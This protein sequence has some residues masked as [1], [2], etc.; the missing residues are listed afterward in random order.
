LFSLFECRSPATKVLNGDDLTDQLQAS[1]GETV[2][3]SAGIRSASFGGAVGRPIV[4]GLGG[5]RVKTT[6][7]RIDSLDVSVTSTDHA[8]TVEP[9]IANQIS[10]LKG[11]STLLYGSGAIGGVVDVETGRIPVEIP[12]KPVSG[13]V[14]LRTTDNANARVGALRLDGRLADSFA[15]HA[16]AF[17]KKAD[18]Y[19]IAGPLESSALRASEGEEGEDEEDTGV[20]EGSRFDIS[21]G[22][23][24]G[25]WIGESGFVGVSISS[26]SADYGLVGGHG[27]EEEGE[28]EGEEEEEGVGRIDLEQTRVDLEAQL[29]NPL[30]GLEKLNFRFGVNDYQHDEI[31]GNGEVGTSFDNQAWE[32]R[33]EVTHTPILGFDGAFGLQLSNREFSALGEEAFVPPVET[34]SAGLFWVGQRAFENVNLEIGA[35]V[36]ETDHSP[37]LAEL[38][39]L[40]FSSASASFGIIAPI[41]DSLKLSAL[42]DYT[43]RAPA[44][45]ELYSD[46]PHLA[47]QTFEIGDP[48]L[49]KESATGLTFGL[50]YQS[51]GFDANISVYRTDFDDFIFQANTGEI[52]DGL[53]VLEYR[54][55]GAE[56]T[57]AD[58]ELGFHLA[59]LF[60]G[61]FDLTAMFDLVSADLNSGGNLPR[62]PADRQGLSLAWDNELWRLKLDVSHVSSQTDTAEL[63]FSTDSYSDVSLRITRRIDIADGRA[64]L[65]IHGRNLGDE[66]QRE[67]VSFVKDFAPAPGRRIEAGVRFEF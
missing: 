17:S 60:G 1:L 45:E 63:E 34:D 31:E 39:D 42:F 61:D 67:H 58:I 8:V 52:E 44:I 14:E 30:P 2:A 35:R 66:E 9:F 26:L 27:H 57:G 28:E 6:E 55:Q 43:E 29:N 56:F 15:W 36:E 21:G 3:N 13:R 54:Q 47:T 40:R 25:S 59:E 53:P 23:I 37:S 41:A 46:G 11:P 18:D 38:P 48:L 62:I 7:D 4:H 10:I 24:G 64:S 20:L 51:E 16:D 22:A 49:T 32:G 5:A 19:E 65:F 12:T 50:N 33:V